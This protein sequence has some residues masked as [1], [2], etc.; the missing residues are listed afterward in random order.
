MKVLQGLKT[1]KPSLGE[2]IPLLKE[3]IK[4][5]IAQNKGLGSTSKIDS[6]LSLTVESTSYSTISVNLVAGPA[7]YSTNSINLLV[8]PVKSCSSNNVFNTLTAGSTI[9]CDTSSDTQCANENSHEDYLND[10]SLKYG[11]IE[12]KGPLLN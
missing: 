1:A 11:N 12:R 5:H 3:A 8:D 7:S 2:T 9:P 4:L 6:T 10:I